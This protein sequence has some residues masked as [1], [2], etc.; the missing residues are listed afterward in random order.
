M[1]KSESLLLQDC[2]PTPVATR[3][4]RWEN[5]AGRGQFGCVW[6]AKLEGDDVAVKIMQVEAKPFW[7]TEKS[8]YGH[9]L[10]II[11]TTKIF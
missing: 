11:W 1:K 4:V 3:T 9:N 6:K 5:I 2:P 8:M 7:L 10:D